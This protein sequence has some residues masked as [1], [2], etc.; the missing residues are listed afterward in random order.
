[1]LSSQALTRAC[2]SKLCVEYIYHLVNWELCLQAFLTADFVWYNVCM[3]AP[4]ALNCQTVF[5]Q[6]LNFTF[7]YEQ[8]PKMSSWSP[9]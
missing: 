6:M 5:D 1:M 7:T 3:T 8:D 2:G 4:A 9:S